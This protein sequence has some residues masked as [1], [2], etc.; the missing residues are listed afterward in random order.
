MRIPP[1]S[2][3]S[4]RFEPVGEPRASIVVLGWKSAPCLIDCLRSIKENVVG[5]AYEVIVA[6]NAPTD[7]LLHDLAEGVGGAVVVRSEINRGFS[8]G[9]NMGVAHSKAEFVVLLNDDTEVLPGWLE[10]L[11]DTADA[12]PGAGAVGGMVLNPDGS[13]QEAGAIL[14]N[15][16]RT[17]APGGAVLPSDLS[18][19]DTVRRV[20]YC[21][22]EALLVR[23]A[24]W[25]A[26]GGLSDDFYPAYYEDV[27]LCLKIAA[28]G[29]EVLYQPAAKV[30]HRRGHSTE[31]RFRGFIL[32]R[33]RRLFVERWSDAL[34][35]RMED[36]PLDSDVV[37]AAINLAAQPLPEPMPVAEPSSITEPTPDHDAVPESEWLR[38]ERSLNSEY[39]A[40][41]EQGLQDVETHVGRLTAANAAQETELVLR[42]ARL[43]EA[44][45]D[46][47]VVRDELLRCRSHL[48]LVE[49][50]ASYRLLDRLVRAAQRFP[51]LS[52]LAARLLR[53]VAPR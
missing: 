46:I 32:E 53:A 20:D 14:W 49:N 21:G 10:S 3:A 1:A 40:T 2:P 22:G 33:S 9:C 44:R 5:V 18:V 7:Q 30:C 4:V 52:E 8:G 27:D 12:Y 42:A 17:A 15:D 39:V 47:G 34:L 16:G 38:R 45:A 19:L 37:L 41:L 35:L 36:S 6:L 50:R 24:T 11:V 13:L 31:T 29:E 48:S 25:E 51:R 26:V 23:R 43:D 28:R